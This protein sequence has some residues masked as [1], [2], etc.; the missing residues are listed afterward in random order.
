MC[1]EKVQCQ[2]V[3]RAPYKARKDD[4]DESSGNAWQWR[5]RQP[6]SALQLEMQPQSKGA[7]CAPA[8]GKQSSGLSGPI[9]SR[10]GLMQISESNGTVAA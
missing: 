8:D 9:P 7:N 10:P 1:E 3:H 5:K 4:N 2:A 6:Q